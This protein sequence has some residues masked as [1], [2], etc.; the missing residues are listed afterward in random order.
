MKSVMKVFAVLLVFSTLANAQDFTGIATYKTK[1]KIDIQMDSTQMNSEMHQKMMDMLK[2]QFEKTF[3]L[4]FNK[5]ESIY[6]EEEKLGA[7]QMGGMQMVV[8]NT[9]GS[10]VLYKN[11]KE[12]RF[13][14]QN[15]VFGKIFLIKDQLE[16]EDWQFEADTKNI[17]EYTC[18]KATIT[19]EQA[20][21]VGGI[22]VNGDKDLSQEKEPEMETV[23][24]TA[25]YTPQIPVNNGPAKY[26]GL[27][28]LI[29]EVNDGSET[30]IC[31]KLVL[32]PADKVEISEPKKGKEVNQEEFDKIMEKKLKE[33]EERYSSERG[34]GH[35]IEIKI[36]G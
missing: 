31:S 14:N 10:D 16:K 8:V 24:V 30:I 23:T 35:N 18:Y 21:L 5:E 25:W 2:K 4:T 22:S 1:R 3:I 32:N 34:D 17:G 13:T 11:T 28:G 15:D 29:L 33:M 12:E 7:P 36:G 27:P 19:R 20:K 9:G 6:K 26:F